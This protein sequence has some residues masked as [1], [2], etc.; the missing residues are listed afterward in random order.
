M[1]VYCWV[2]LACAGHLSLP[3]AYFEYCDAKVVY[4]RSKMHMVARMK[5]I[6]S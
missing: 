3:L 1:E 4:P 5:E 6:L 2:G